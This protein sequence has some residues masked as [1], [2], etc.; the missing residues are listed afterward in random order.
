LLRD[1]L[2]MR[3][4]Q[5]RRRPRAGAEPAILWFSWAFRPPLGIAGLAFL[6]QTGGIGDRP[7][8]KATATIA[9]DYR[10]IIRWWTI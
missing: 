8:L 4:E 6:E 3:V 5:R 2:G 9:C 1:E 10:T 7:V